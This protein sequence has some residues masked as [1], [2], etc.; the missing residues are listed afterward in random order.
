M[1]R[2]DKRRAQHWQAAVQA[3]GNVP[4]WLAFRYLFAQ[5]YNRHQAQACQVRTKEM[6]AQ[7][8][9]QLVQGMGGSLMA[10]PPQGLD[11]DAAWQ[12]YLEAVRP[13][14]L[15]QARSLMAWL[16]CQQ[17]PHPVLPCQC[18]PLERDDQR[19]RLALLLGDMEVQQ[20][21]NAAG[22]IAGKGY[23]EHRARRGGR[24]RR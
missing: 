24:R 12:A 22:W 9:Q 11:T 4:R 15:D 17:W 2:N 3:A 20:R 19:I 7:V 5:Q 13:L 18:H 1:G 23:P 21:C 14:D 8:A 16:V 6:A 10:P